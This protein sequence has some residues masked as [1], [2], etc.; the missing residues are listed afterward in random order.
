MPRFPQRVPYRIRGERRSRIA[1][2]YPGF[3]FVTSFLNSLILVLEAF[4]GARR[5]RGWHPG[6]SGW[7]VT[8]ENPSSG[9]YGIPQAHEEADGWY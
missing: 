2:S 5:F 9:A 6:E 4:Q 1:A 3:T 7:D 8:A